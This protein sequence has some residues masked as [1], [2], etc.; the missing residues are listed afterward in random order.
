MPL[1][2]LSQQVKKNLALP[3]EVF[4][5][6]S[7]QGFFVNRKFFQEPTN[8]I[9]K[10]E[11]SKTKVNKAFYDDRILLIDSNVLKKMISKIISH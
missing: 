7:F 5:F 1:Y 11:K 2:W 6:S 8:G 3:R 9:D 10:D 4:K